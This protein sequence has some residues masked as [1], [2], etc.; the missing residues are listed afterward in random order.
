VTS[1]IDFRRSG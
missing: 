1:W